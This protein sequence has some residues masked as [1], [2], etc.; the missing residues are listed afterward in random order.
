MRMR[1]RGRE[2]GRERNKKI[3][4]ERYRDIESGRETYFCSPAGN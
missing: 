1:E 2:G 3:E 4:S